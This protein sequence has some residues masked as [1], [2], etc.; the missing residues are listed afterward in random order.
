VLKKFFSFSSLVALLSVPQAFAIGTP[1]TIAFAN[2]YQGGKNL[3]RY[4]DF[5][6][7]NTRGWSLGTIGTLTNGL[8]TGSPTFGSG[9][10][11]TLS[12]NAQSSSVMGGNYYLR[13]IDASATTVGNMLASDAL[14]VPVNPTTYS[15]SFDYRAI[16][17]ASGMNMSGTSSNSYAWAA[18]DVTNSSFMS[19][20]GNFCTIQITGTGTCTGSFQTNATTASIR[21]IF[22]NMNATTPV[23]VG[24]AAAIGLKN[25][26]ISPQVYNQGYAG[27]PTVPYTPTI[28]G[29]G[30]ATNVVGSSSRVGDRLVGD[31]AFTSGT[32]TGATAEITI[33]YNGGN[34]N[35][36]INAA[37]LLT[38]NTAS[39][40]GYVASGINS[41]SSFTVISPSTNGNFVE[42]GTQA[43]STNGLTASA[44]SAL[45]SSGN[46]ISIHYSVPIIGWSSNTATSADSN[47][48]AT[49]F[50][51]NTASN[52][53]STTQPYIYTVVSDDSTGSYNVS[54]GQYKIPS[55]G[56]YSFDAINYCGT[57][58]ASP[59]I[60]VGGVEVAQGVPAI[61][62]ASTGSV[63]YE[64]NFTAEQL[65]D[66]RPSASC[67]AA[68]SAVTNMF[69]GHKITGSNAVQAPPTVAFDYY[70]STQSLTGSW[71][72]LVESTKSTDSLG[73]YNTSTGLYP[74]PYTGTYHC[75]CK[76]GYV[77]TAGALLY[78]RFAI[79]GS[80]VGSEGFSQCGTSGYGGV[81]SGDEI[82]VLAGQTIEC[83]ATV[84][85][86]GSINSGTSSFGCHRV[87]Y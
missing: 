11:G 4:G 19:S 52:S 86:N 68:G 84:S 77:G 18:Y 82:F 32:P 81:S 49:T 37:G 43:T 44:G 57:T 27:T 51:V 2:V 83:D 46:S 54:T 36:T 53:V 26:L 42:I 55:S 20:V 48:M 9:A 61:G 76:Y 8:P 17:N 87:G 58:T 16:I 33:G 29:F 22:Y 62:S 79:N 56:R 35:V 74:A 21:L 25:F 10:A 75:D 14:T 30:T 39:V 60:Y 67:T 6:S 1:S 59:N 69:Y 23:G 64:N 66:V 41:A 28:T 50:S 24:G 13:Y 3:I 72:A 70:G 5:E 34:G 7:G 38:P 12:I 85:V 80:Q 65:V 31:V 73:L 45:L 15:V 71:S 47:P 40:V 78:T 63:H